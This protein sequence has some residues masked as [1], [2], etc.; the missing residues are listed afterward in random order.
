[1]QAL[2]CLRLLRPLQPLR[3]LSEVWK[4]CRGAW[5]SLVAIYACLDTAILLAN[6]HIV[7]VYRNQYRGEYNH[8]ESHRLDV[9]FLGP[10]GYIYKRVVS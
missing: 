4:V 7:L 5:D 1:M 10:C 6:H 2:R 3:T 8:G 9:C